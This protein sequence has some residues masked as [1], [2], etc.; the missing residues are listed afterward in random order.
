M[1]TLS[2]QSYHEKKDMGYAN[3]NKRYAQESMRGKRKGIGHMK[4]LEKKKKK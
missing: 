3:R 1:T 2:L 4:V